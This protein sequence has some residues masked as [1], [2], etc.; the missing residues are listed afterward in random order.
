MHP[1]RESLS[2]SDLCRRLLKGIRERYP[3]KRPKEKETWDVSRVLTDLARINSKTCTLKELSKKTATLLALATLWRPRS[4][5]SRIRLED[6]RFDGE[7]NL[8]LTVTQPKEGDWKETSLSR[9]EDESLC[10]V[11]CVEDYLERTRVKRGRSGSGSSP[12]R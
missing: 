8:E 5:L 3:K 6:V 7:G 1:K 11:R 10:P 9:L 4:D 2:E 12:K